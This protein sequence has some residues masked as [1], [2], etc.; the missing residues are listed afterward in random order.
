MSQPVDNLT[1]IAEYIAGMVHAPL[2]Y[3]DVRPASS[4]SQERVAA[5]LAAVDSYTTLSLKFTTPTYEEAAAYSRA[6]IDAPTNDKTAIGITD[7]SYSS[8]SNSTSNPDDDKPNT[9]MI[10]GIAIAVV[11]VGALL[12]VVAVRKC[13]SNDQGTGVRLMMDGDEMRF[14]R[15]DLAAYHNI[16]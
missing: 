10:A 4:S 12:A 3:V 5:A 14:R 7:V 16:K 2:Q 13:K 1:T 6:F 9:G 8:Y 11:V 15:D